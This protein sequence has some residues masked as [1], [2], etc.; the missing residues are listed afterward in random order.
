MIRLVVAVLDKLP[1][2][3]L[4]DFAGETVWLLRRGDRLT[5][6]DASDMWT[7]E[8]LAGLPPYERAPLPDL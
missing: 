4:L 7:P 2:A 6:N 8:L 5:I 3:A 1:G